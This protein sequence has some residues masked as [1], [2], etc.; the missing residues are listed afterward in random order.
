MKKPELI[1]II[2]EEINQI[3][4]ETYMDNFSVYENE[5]KKRGFK[6]TNEDYSSGGYDDLWYKNL[7]L[8]RFCVSFSSNDLAI[9]SLSKKHQQF[10]YYIWFEPFPKFEK[11]F[12][13]LLKSKNPQ[14]GEM[15]NYEAG[16]IDF[17]EGLFKIDDEKFIVKFF[18]KVDKAL[19]MALKITDVKYLSPEESKNWGRPA[20][21]DLNIK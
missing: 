21:S 15:I 16:E 12:F 8:G 18:N 11:K 1:Q 13:G 5:F 9:N 19:D 3:I 4:N 10:T 20:F 2:K 17:G 6:R 14:W 7:P